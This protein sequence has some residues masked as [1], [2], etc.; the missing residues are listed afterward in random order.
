MQNAG[1]ISEDDLLCSSP[2]LL[3]SAQYFLTKNAICLGELDYGS[4][5]N[6]LAFHKEDGRRRNLTLCGA[7]CIQRMA[8]SG[9][10]PTA[11]FFVRSSLVFFWNLFCKLSHI[12]RHLS[13][14]VSTTSK[15]THTQNGQ[16]PSW[17]GWCVVCPFPLG[18]RGVG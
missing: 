16:G 6:S 9:H 1:H 2:C 12:Q 10:A 14:Q 8:Y 18:A 15:A 5:L 17:S 11:F 13:I 4:R 3:C 7:G